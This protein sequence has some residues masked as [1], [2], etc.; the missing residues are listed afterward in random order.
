MARYQRRTP[1]LLLLATILLQTTLPI[2]QQV[3]AQSEDYFCGLDWIHAAEACPHPCPTGRDSECLDA[4]LNPSYGCFYFTGCWDR[5]QAGEFGDNAFTPTA[6]P[7]VEA[8]TP[9]PAGANEGRPTESPVGERYENF[10]GGTYL[11]AMVTCDVD[12]N[13][14]GGGATPCP[15]GDSD[16]STIAGETCHA[17]DCALSLVEM[18]SADLIVIMNG[19]SGTMAGED[20]DTFLDTLSGLVEKHLKGLKIK[21]E[22][23][24]LTGQVLGPSFDYIDVT[25]SVTATYRPVEG[26]EAQNLSKIVAEYITTSR[27]TVLS[28]LKTSAIMSGSDF[29]M[30]L[31]RIGVG[32]GSTEDPTT[33]PT[34]KPTVKVRCV[35]FCSFD[36]SC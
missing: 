27:M 7:V 18:K 5:V 16:C 23:M 29:F 28:R 30:E 10:C 25:I 24:Q 20:R 8:P 21:F 19:V 9:N 14:E 15:Y 3:S 33:R 12:V 6:S 35:V 36:I 26:E 34:G 1:L 32:L 31:S 22:G 2:I 13:D 11:D 4:N 17:L